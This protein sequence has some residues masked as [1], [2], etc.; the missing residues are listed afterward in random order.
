MSTYNPYAF[1]SYSINKESKAVHH[2]SRSPRSKAIHRR[3]AALSILVM[4][5]IVTSL[6]LFKVTASPSSTDELI[7][8]EYVI[9]V[10]SGD[11]L[12]DIANRHLEQTADTSYAVFLIKDRNQLSSNLITPG[13]QL[14]I[15]IP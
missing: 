13:Q 12:W 7:E 1:R 14:I 15:P 9:A 8:G 4:L 10:H 2:I 5:S 11:T 6:F 3:R